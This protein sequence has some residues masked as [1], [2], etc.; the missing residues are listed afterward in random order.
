MKRL[1]RWIVLW[2]GLIA[3]AAMLA[4]VTAMLIAEDAVLEDEVSGVNTFDRTNAQ[5]EN[6]QSDLVHRQPLGITRSGST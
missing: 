5:E 2:R 6:Q 1:Y 4:Q 3:V